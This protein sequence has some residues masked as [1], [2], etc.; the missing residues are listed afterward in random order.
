L[1]FASFWSESRAS[2]DSL[3]AAALPL[4]RAA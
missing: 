3:R 1:N 4:A 2:I